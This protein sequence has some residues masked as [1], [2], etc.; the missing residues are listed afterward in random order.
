M[1]RDSR[2]PSCP[3][4]WMEHAPVMIWHA[5]RDG[6]RVWKGAAFHNFTGMQVPRDGAWLG[7]VH[8]EDTERCVDIFRTCCE[9]AWPF[10]LDYR[11]HH[12][13]GTYRWVMDRGVPR[14]GDSGDFLGY[15][16]ACVD[17][18]ERRVLE[19]QLAAHLHRMRH[20]QPS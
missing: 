20:R 3:D 19:D 18:H 14:R 5:D 7:A 12:R 9:S 8:P 10:A 15:V 16:G 17:I 1:K 13:N 2:D 6:V 4:E 11:L